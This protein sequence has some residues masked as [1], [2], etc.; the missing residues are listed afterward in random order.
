MRSRSRDALEA[1]R[2][3]SLPMALGEG[4]LRRRP[5]DV[6][7]ALDHGVDTRDQGLVARLDFGQPAARLAGRPILPWP[8]RDGLELKK[9]KGRKK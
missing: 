8:G 2:S 4:I 1:S 3:S 7:A 6:E 5:R 9:K